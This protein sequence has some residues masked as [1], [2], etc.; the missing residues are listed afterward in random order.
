MKRFLFVLIIVCL[1]VSAN[2]QILIS[3]LLGDKLNSDGIEF[4][5]E[6]GLTSSN[7]NGFNNNGAS[8]DFLL[9]FYFNVRMNEK[10]Y[11]HTGVQGICNFGMSKLSEQDIQL[12]NSQKLEYPGDYSQVINTFQVPLLVQY[13][14][15]NY[16]YVEAGPQVGWLYN[17]YVY[18]TS[19]Y[20]N[21]DIKIKDPNKELLNWFDA[22]FAAGAGYRLMKGK[23]W[24][25]GAR[26]YQGVTNAFNHV[27]GSRNRS[28]Y[29]VCKVP[30]GAAPKENKGQSDSS[31]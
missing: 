26:Y 29:L 14:F 1:S 6:G 13:R 4:G 12:L 21:R 16:M 31:N 5:L 17:S 27:S 28:L 23:G 25:I 3:L 2:S 30:I 24:S 10:L 20:D 19:D 8:S 18:Y 15:K 7:V 9:G 11:F 22:G